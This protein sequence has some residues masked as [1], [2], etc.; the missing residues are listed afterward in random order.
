MNL[1]LRVAK[2]DLDALKTIAR[3]EKTTLSNLV[4]EAIKP[5]LEKTTPMPKKAPEETMVS[6]TVSLSLDHM[7]AFD[8]LCKESACP[9][10]YATRLAV[11][12]MLNAPNNELQTNA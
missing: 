8:D 6:T 2:K 3:L 9:M 1:Q 10:D 11:E 5:Y 4:F 7:Q 12:K